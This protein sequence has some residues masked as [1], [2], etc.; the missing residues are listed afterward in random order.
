ML[1]SFIRPVIDRS[2][3]TWGRY[4]AQSGISATTI[5]ALSFAMVPV[6]L[7]L[8]IAGHFVGALVLILVNRFLDGLDGA[9]ARAQV[10]GV[11]DFG[12]FLD[13][14]GDFIL[15][16]GV[17]F[18]FAIHD[19]SNATSAVFL[20]F[21][22]M[23]TASS[24]LAYAIMA[25]KRNIH[26][27]KRGRK[28]FAYLGGLAEGSETMI[29]MLLMCLVPAYFAAIAV[30]FGVLCWLTTFGRIAQGWR[31]FGPYSSQSS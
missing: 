27:E 15:Y 20:L 14:V 8:I 13:I 16:G 30:L 21:S 3:N 23:G 7:G 26:T 11:S 10:N 9:V 2:L 19:A 24:F 31:D 12:A 29:V 22:Y 18:A 4:V 5:T 17:V 1:D 28:S 25:A 6:I